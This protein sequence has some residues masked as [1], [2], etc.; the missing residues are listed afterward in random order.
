MLC[1]PWPLVAAP[2]DAVE[3]LRR[4][5]QHDEANL[6][7]FRQYV[8]TVTDQAYDRNRLDKAQSFEVN[9]ISGDMYWRR[10]TLDQ[11][12]LSEDQV[13]VERE[14]LRQH[15]RTGS[16]RSTAWRKERLDLEALPVTHQVQYRGTARANGRDCHLLELKPRPNIDHGIF[17]QA[18]MRLHIDREEFHWVSAEIEFL[19]RTGFHLR[20]LLLGR[21]SLPYSNGFELAR[22]EEGLWHPLSYRATFRPFRS[23]LYFAD[24]RRFTSESNLLP[25]EG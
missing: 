11:Q 5:I 14:R 7:R 3:I 10:L 16:A 25:Q 22:N 19:Q 23:E 13:A 6:E 17:S 4:A 1:L 18:Q 8:F 24:Y 9:L 21:L 20:Q 12:P 15:L 2:P